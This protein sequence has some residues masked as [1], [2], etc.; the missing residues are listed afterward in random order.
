MHKYRKLATFTT[1]FVILHWIA[2]I[3]TMTLI[4]RPITHIWT[5]TAEKGSCGNLMA[6]QIANSVLNIIIDIWVVVLPLPVIWGI[7]ITLTRKW[8]ITASFM[9]GVT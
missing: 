8:G 1:T 3:L 5:S 2:G 6:V 7:Q 4:C 9:I